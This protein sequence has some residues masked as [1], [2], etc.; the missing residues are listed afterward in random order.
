MN[1]EEILSDPIVIGLDG[2]PIPVGDILLAEKKLKSIDF[3]SDITNRLTVLEKK[4][5]QLEKEKTLDQSIDTKSGFFGLKK[6]TVQKRI[7]LFE[8]LGSTIQTQQK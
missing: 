4:F 5:E 1:N 8:K 6:S 7:L 3:F 2:K